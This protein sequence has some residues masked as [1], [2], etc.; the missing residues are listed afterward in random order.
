[1]R[2]T[3]SFHSFAI[4]F[5]SLVTIPWSAV[6][7]AIYLAVAFL[8]LVRFFVGLAFGRRLMQASQRIYEPR[9]TR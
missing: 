7:A 4:V 2:T 9:V 1:M 8:L 3:L 6:A 5:D